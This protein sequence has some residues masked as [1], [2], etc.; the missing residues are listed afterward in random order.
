LDCFISHLLYDKSNSAD[1]QY[2]GHPDQACK[3]DADGLD[4]R[5]P[6]YAVLL[7]NQAG[8][9]LGESRSHIRW[10]SKIHSFADTLMSLM[11]WD[12]GNQSLY[13]TPV[14]VGATGPQYRIGAI[15]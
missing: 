3:T 6:G 8:V 1:T 14:V 15:K 5:S 13:P 10:H 2:H 7:S 4:P 11:E 12:N 9:V